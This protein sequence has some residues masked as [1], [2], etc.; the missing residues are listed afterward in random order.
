MWRRG[1]GTPAC[2]IG[3]RGEGCGCADVSGVREAAQATNEE[4]AA[5]GVRGTMG[6]W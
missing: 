4:A 1:L 2:Y 5:A 3:R 6:G